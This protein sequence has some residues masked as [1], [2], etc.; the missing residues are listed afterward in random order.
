MVDKTG[1][2]YTSNSELL[3]R[4]TI[5]QAFENDN[6]LYLKEPD[7]LPDDFEIVKAIINGNEKELD[8]ITNMVHKRFDKDYFVVRT[9][10]GFLEI[11]PKDVNKGTA[12]K[13][14]AQYLGLNMEQTMAMGDRDNDLPMLEVAVKAIAMGNAVDNLKKHSDFVT[15][16]NDHDGVGVAINKFVLNK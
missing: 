6:G 8:N 3:D 14:L 4:Y 9:G 5:K 1:N 13:F 2:T 15:S 10:V 12:I 7:Q 16:D 11:F